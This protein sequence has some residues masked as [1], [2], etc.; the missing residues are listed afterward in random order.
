MG[1]ASAFVRGV[2]RLGGRLSGLEHASFVGL[3]AKAGDVRTV[4]IGKPVRKGNVAAL[5]YI[6]LA[7]KK[8][9]EVEATSRAKSPSPLP[10]PRSQGGFFE[11]A[12]DPRAPIRLIL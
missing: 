7:P 11:P 4:C 2:L 1:F 5:K 10:L 6:S 8:P 12:I 9:I 3:R